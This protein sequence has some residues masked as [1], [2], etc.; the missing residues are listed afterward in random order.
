MENSREIG[1]ARGR[2]NSVSVTE[3]SVIFGDQMK[4]SVVGTGRFLQQISTWSIARKKISARV[5]EWIP[6]EKL[7][8]EE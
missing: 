5:T 8:D 4:N 6:D 7:V 1:S 3:F 2:N